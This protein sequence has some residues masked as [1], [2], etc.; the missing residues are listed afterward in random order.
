MTAGWVGLFVTI[1]QVGGIIG[2][3]IGGLVTDTF[4]W[5]GI[6]FINVPLSI[7]ILL[8]GLMFI[9]RDRVDPEASKQRLDVT[10]AGYFASG[11]FMLLFGLTY[12]ANHPN[13]F[14]SPIPWVSFAIGSGVLEA[15]WLKPGR[16]D[17]EAARRA[18]SALDP[19][20]RHPRNQ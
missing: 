8:L 11:V 5:R 14:A 7:V 2:P 17:R 20:M 19:R 16:E 1:F 15:G 4:S 13:D 10:G 9:P 3:N 18:Y 6:F 12:L